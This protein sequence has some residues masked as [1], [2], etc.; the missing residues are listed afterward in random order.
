MEWWQEIDAGSGSRLVLVLDTQYS[1]KWLK[2]VRRLGDHRYVALQT[3]YYAPTSASLEAG[4]RFTVGLFTSEWSDYNGANINDVD[5]HDKSRDLRVVYGVSACWTDFTFHL[6]TES[7]IAQHWNA[8]F[9]KFTRPLVKATN[10][11]VMGN[12]CCCFTCLVKCI[13]RKR[14]RWAPP[15][16]LDTGHGF[17]LVTS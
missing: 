8:N 1:Y 12:M 9:P 10:F 4:K 7:D 5:F 2:Q 13:K 3:C 6:P 17:R 15:H 11:T 16:E 14:M